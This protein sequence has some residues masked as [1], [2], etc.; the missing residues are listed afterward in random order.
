[1]APPRI[2]QKKLLTKIRLAPSGCWLW[3]GATYPAGYGKT[4]VDGRTL[5]AHRVS[6]ELFVGP[7]PEGL[8]LDHLCRVRN[9]VNPAHLEPVTAA[10]NTLR[11]NGP[12]AVNARK[13]SCVRGHPLSGNNLYVC[14]R[15]RRECRK[16]RAA[17]GRRWMEG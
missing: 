1:M 16:C 13:S 10:E 9:C 4:G 15:G 5:L 17:A 7:I 14:P 6:Y 11:G 2:D 3:T 8:Q 12:A